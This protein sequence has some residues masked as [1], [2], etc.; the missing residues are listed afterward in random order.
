M[1]FFSISENLPYLY[2]H[3]FQHSD[4]G[5]IVADMVLSALLRMLGYLLHFPDLVNCFIVHGGGDI[6]LLG[7]VYPR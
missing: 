3:V 7:K 5:S 2:Q 4:D 6:N 1:A